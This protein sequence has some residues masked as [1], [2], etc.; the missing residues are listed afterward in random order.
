MILGGFS[1][2]A[3]T[4]LDLV[5]GQVVPAAG[6]IALCTGD[7]PEH[8][9]REDIDAAQARGVRGVFLEGEE[10]WPDD[11]QQEMLQTMQEAGL[12]VE[13]VI[14]EGIGHGA[15]QDFPQKLDRALSFIF[16][17]PID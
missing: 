12:P 4:A 13:L 1:S 5:F 14:N 16:D 3:T 10:N 2:G 15:P 9:T 17:S 6:F 8:F 11:D 7:K